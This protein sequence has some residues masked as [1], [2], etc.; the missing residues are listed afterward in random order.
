[1][2]ARQYTKNTVSPTEAAGGYDALA[3]AQPWPDDGSGMEQAT[4]QQNYDAAKQAGQIKGQ[5][6][7]PMSQWVDATP[8]NDAVK[9]FKAHENAY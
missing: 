7:R 1:T 4:L 2:Y 9:V 5:G 3:K 6:N 8:W